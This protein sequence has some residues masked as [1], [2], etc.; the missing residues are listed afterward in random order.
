MRSKPYERNIVAWFRPKESIVGLMAMRPSDAHDG[1]TIRN[2][3]LPP[4]TKSIFENKHWACAV[5]LSILRLSSQNFNPQRDGKR[6]GRPHM[7]P[8]TS[9]ISCA[10]KLETHN[11]PSRTLHGTTQLGR[12]LTRLQVCLNQ[13]YR[14]TRA[15]VGPSCISIQKD[16][17]I[18]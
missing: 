5:Q 4:R 13:H 16:Q 1:V 6:C 11:R 18:C 9:P 8:L 17:H 3:R 12:K 2:T 10:A 15:Q 7:R 14:P